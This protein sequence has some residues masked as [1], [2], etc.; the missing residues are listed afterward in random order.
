M[1]SENMKKN[2]LSD[3][4]LRLLGKAQ[5]PFSFLIFFK[6]YT[7][8]KKGEKFFEVFE[9]CPCPLLDFTLFP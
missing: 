9:F 4:K 2:W 3:R 7:T 1:R 8:L 6:L 5:N